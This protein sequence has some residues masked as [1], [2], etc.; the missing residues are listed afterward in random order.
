MMNNMNEL[1]SLD[2]AIIEENDEKRDYAL[3]QLRREIETLDI[4][5]VNALSEPQTVDAGAKSIDPATINAL[6]LSI[7]PITITKVLEFMHSW[8]TRKEGR[9]IKI[10]IQKSRG[11]TI[12]VEIPSS[13]SSKELKQLIK[14]VETSIS[15]NSK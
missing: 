6:L 8:V 10:K 2:I 5:D 11:T 14:T 15:N 7:T 4:G 1:L 13:M 9:T 12:E 3:R